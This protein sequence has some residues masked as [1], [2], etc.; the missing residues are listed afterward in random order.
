MSD[1]QTGK[2]QAEPLLIQ[3]PREGLEIEADSMS[4]SKARQHLV[5]VNDDKPV[6]MVLE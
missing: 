1:T 4:S 2:A 6:K 3:L 5:I